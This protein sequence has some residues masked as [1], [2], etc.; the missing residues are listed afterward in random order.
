MT[1]V[2]DDLQREIDKLV[3]SAEAWLDSIGRGVTA[4]HADRANGSTRRL[5]P[6]L[7]AGSLRRSIPSL[8][9]A[10]LSGWPASQP[11]L[12]RSQGPAPSP[13]A[14]MNPCRSAAAHWQTRLS[15]RG[16][17]SPWFCWPRS[18]PSWAGICPACVSERRQRALDL[19]P[20]EQR[21]RMIAARV[22]AT[23]PTA[24][25]PNVCRHCGK[26]DPDNLIPH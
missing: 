19:D 7:G 18:R 15:R 6:T 12:R 16:M 11:I 10:C 26:R 22:E 23:W 21:C 25:D 20:D 17:L 4:E 5:R 8:W 13:A 3:Q 24:V 1:T 14:S 2:D 9:P